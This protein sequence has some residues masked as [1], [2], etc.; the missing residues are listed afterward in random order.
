MASVIKPHEI[1]LNS[2]KYPVIGKV[3]PILSSNFATKMVVGDFTKDSNPEISSWV[4]SD[5]RGGMLIEE[6]NELKD[7]ERCWWSTCQLGFKGH[8]LLPR[9][10]TSVTALASPA[11]VDPTDASGTDWISLDNAYDNVRSTYATTNQI[12]GGGSNWSNYG[13]FTFTSSTV[14]H[15]RF[16]AGGG[17]AGITAIDIDVYDGS[18]HSVYTGAF[19]FGSVY[20][21]A[22]A[23]T[24]ATLVRVRFQNTDASGQ[25]GWLYEIDVI[26]SGGS[27]LTPVTFENFNSILYL[28]A[29]QYLFKLNSAGD[30][31]DLV[32]V[33]DAAITDLISSVGTRLYLF[34]G[35]SDNYWH[36]N[37][38][39]VCI[40]S[41]SALA[42][43]GIAW[44]S[45]LGKINTNGATAF[46]TDPNA[47][48]P[49][50]TSKGSLAD[51]GIAQ[52]DVQRLGTYR[53]AAGDTTVYA[54]TKKG[55]FANDYT[56]A[57]WIATELEMPDQATTGKGFVHWRENAYISAGLGVI[58]Y[59]TGQAGTSIR[60]VGLDRDDGLPQLRGGEIVEFIKGYNEFFALVDSTYEGATSYST[61]MAYDGYGWQCWWEAG[62]VNYNMDCGAV[63]SD[64]AYRLWF[65]CE[66]TIY[67]IPLQSNIRNPKKIT[68]FPYKSAGVHITPWFDANWAGQKL[69]LALRIFCKDTTANETVVVDYRIDHATTALAATWTNLGTIAAAG[70]GV[71]TTYTFGT[72]AVGVNFK[73]IQF[74]FS[75][76]NTTSTLSP[77]VQY[78][79]LEYQKIITPTWNWM[80]TIDCTQDYDD[81]T[82][83]QLLDA[84]VTAAEKEVLVP[85]TFTDT[86]YYVRVKEVQG[87]RLSGDGRKG[88]YKVLVSKPR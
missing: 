20:L 6:M 2:V 29:G 33:P 18:W 25:Y 49:T 61:V 88:T 80:F 86:T 69:A 71:E 51:N 64:T 14:T 31:F 54:A 5:Q 78:A 52:N 84:V 39:E 73:A 68:S 55:L 26:T 82:P 27:T 85:F 21:K 60:T 17:H 15:V 66:N 45:K 46:S 4:I 57:T 41:N 87:E 12:A 58:A 8:I 22:A 67:Y 81:R 83:D 65:S 34:L 74:R 59:Q 36:M 3:Q 24:G 62:T 23:Y 50:W 9:L 1:E 43:K 38:S 56:N 70:N 42:N 19:T 76:K 10:A 79:V 63:S 77:D 11:I 44:D 47:A 7:A 53:D 72:A 13:Q 28:A 37:T 30:G 48:A 75:L 40:V 32:A 16:Q 35:D